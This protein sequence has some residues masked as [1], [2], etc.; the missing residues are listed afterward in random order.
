MQNMNIQQEEEILIKIGF[1]VGI[2]S[3]AFPFGCTHSLQP[4]YLKSEA[5]KYPVSASN[6]G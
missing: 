3:R 5:L 4:L 6:V 1:M 2:H